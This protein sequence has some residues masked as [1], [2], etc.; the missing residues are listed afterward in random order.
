[1]HS[2]EAH[3]Y[4]E[5]SAQTYLHAQALTL[6]LTHTHRLE[7]C[8]QNRQEQVWPKLLSTLSCKGTIHV[9]SIH[10]QME[11][12]LTQWASLSGLYS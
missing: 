8:S 6:T 12:R 4:S 11:E 5:E 7:Q 2:D 9:A 3:I 10:T 1:M